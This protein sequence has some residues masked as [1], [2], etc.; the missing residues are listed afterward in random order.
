[1]ELR[2]KDGCTPDSI[3]KLGCDVKIRSMQ[4]EEL[5]NICVDSLMTW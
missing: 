4:V 5:S 2:C 3:I 1:M